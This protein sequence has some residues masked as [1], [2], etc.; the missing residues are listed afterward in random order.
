MVGWTART[1][2]HDMV[3]LVALVILNVAIQRPP[4]HQ[5]QESI[6]PELNMFGLPI[7]K[8]GNHIETISSDTTKSDPLF[9]CPA[10]Q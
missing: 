6:E 4:E 8:S 2:V 1:T 10:F 5:E 9:G 3:M 7:S